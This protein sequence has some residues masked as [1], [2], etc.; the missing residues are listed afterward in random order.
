LRPP[1]RRGGCERDEDRQIRQ[2]ARHHIDARVGIRQLDMDVQAAQHAAPADHLQIVHDCVVALC[3]GLLRLA[4]GGSGMR[5]RG[6][7]G[8]PMRRGDGGDHMA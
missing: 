8:E 1:E 4:P 3:L 5:A 7:D 6:E 2:H